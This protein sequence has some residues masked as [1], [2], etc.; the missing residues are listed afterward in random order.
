VLNFTTITSFSM[1]YETKVLLDHN[2]TAKAC[3]FHWWITKKW[4]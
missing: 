2:L 3:C 1:G 4:M